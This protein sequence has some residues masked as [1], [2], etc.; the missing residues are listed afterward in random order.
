M[1][2]NPVG[3]GVLPY[4]SLV[5]ALVGAGELEGTGLLVGTGDEEGDDEQPQLSASAKPPP[6]HVV[7]R[8]TTG[9]AASSVRIFWRLEGFNIIDSPS[10]KSGSIIIPDKYG[11][12]KVLAYCLSL[13]KGFCRRIFLGLQIRRRTG[14]DKFHPG[15]FSGTTCHKNVTGA[16]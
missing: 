10:H 13:V 6:V 12:V 7:T 3:V 8:M 2:Y 14:G 16:V 5:G 4:M 9:I 11:F 15:Q 1:P